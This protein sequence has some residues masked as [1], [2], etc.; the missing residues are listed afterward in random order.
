MIPARRLGSVEER[1]SA[2]GDSPTETSVMTRSKHGLCNLRDKHAHSD[3]G[4]TREVRSEQS[5]DD[6]LAHE[7]VTEWVTGC[8]RV[9]RS[10]RR[11]VS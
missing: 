1:A 7:R 6:R 3:S 9:T 8:S 5:A 2:L 10:P 11:Y 4:L